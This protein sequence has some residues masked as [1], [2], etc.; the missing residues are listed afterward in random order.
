LL[1]DPQFVTTPVRALVQT[2]A[3]ANLGREADRIQMGEAVNLGPTPRVA[4][5]LGH[6]I[7]LAAEVGGCARLNHWLTPVVTSSEAAP[8]R[9]HPSGGAR[10][11]ASGHV[12]EARLVNKT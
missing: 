12:F 7:G 6:R 9:D 2:G 8:V 1:R 4:S 5:L 11:H 10:A 3:A